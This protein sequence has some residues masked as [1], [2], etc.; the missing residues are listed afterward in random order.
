MDKDG[1]DKNECASVCYCAS[2]VLERTAGDVNARCLMMQ[3]NDK[4]LFVF[5]LKSVHCL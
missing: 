5:Y 3:V 1:K 2:V 4:V